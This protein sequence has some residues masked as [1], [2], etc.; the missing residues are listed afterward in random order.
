[1]RSV[2][3]WTP[4]P[5]AAIPDYPRLID[6]CDHYARIDP[7]G[8]AVI[9]LDGARYSH[10][11]F[12]D[13]VHRLAAGLRGIGIRPGDRVATL[14]PPHSDA[15]L[16]FLA[17]AAI[18]AVWVGLNPR[19]TLDELRYVVGHARPALIL[20]RKTIGTRDFLADLQALQAEFAPACG[21]CLFDGAAGPFPGSDV[22]F[23]FGAQHAGPAVDP[24]EP[25]LLVYTSGTTGKPKGALLRQSG[26]VA[27]SRVQAHHYG[28]AGGRSLNPLPINH[29]G[30]I[31]DTATTILVQGGAQI[32]VDEF[33][34][35][36]LLAAFA[37]ERI[38]VWGGVPTMFQMIM[39]HP[40]FDPACLA[41]V[42]R[43][44][45]SGAPMPR[46]VAE[47]LARF[48]LPMHNFYGMTETTGSICFT[49]PDADLD[50][51]VD[52][53]GLPEPSYELRIADPDRGTV[54]ADG[55]VGEIQVRS[56]GVLHSYLD[57]PDAT[58]AAFAEEGWFRTGDLGLRDAG[59]CIRLCGRSKEMFKSGGYNVYPLE[60]EAVLEAHDEVAVAVV[61][62]RPDPV[63]HE[64]GHAFVVPVPG[65]SPSPEA[66]KDH[67][68]RHLANYK[69]PKSFTLT[70]DLPILPVGKVDRAALRRRAANLP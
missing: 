15:W 8:D 5:L 50:Q 44:A 26:L 17:T 6:Y 59:G 37:R 53:V 61:V 49:S 2:P 23:E 29:V 38:T 28:M 19:Y 62:S 64:V 33:D 67:A 57:A 47:H 35:G 9:D 46:A 25:C 11:A 54:C 68:R 55:E 39:A 69:M 63:F 30:S 3:A 65:A 48:G 27:C 42:R 60:I 43:I 21:V 14:S 66:L 18:G 70:D 22:L 16:A 1:M 58:R 7:E 32:F 20:A 36:R 52:T 34:P 40:A 41:D 24:A 56:P 31:C 51:L 10:A 13:R 4:T 12:A 45:W